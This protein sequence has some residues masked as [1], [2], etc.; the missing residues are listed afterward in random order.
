[1]PKYAKLN[2]FLLEDYFDSDLIYIITLFLL[3]KEY[4]I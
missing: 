4:I 1:M 3:D 2:Q